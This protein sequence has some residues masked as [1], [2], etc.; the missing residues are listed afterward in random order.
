MEDGCSA[1]RATIKHKPSGH[2][3]DT[4]VVG[5]DG[6]IGELPGLDILIGGSV[7]MLEDGIH[8]LCGE[9]GQDGVM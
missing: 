1:L 2:S 8:L 4:P 3:R 5:Q 7:P 6:R 9:V